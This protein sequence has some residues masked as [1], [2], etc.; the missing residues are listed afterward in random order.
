MT[1]TAGA[2]CVKRVEY[3]LSPKVIWAIVREVDPSSYG[4][5][6]ELWFFQLTSLA[7][8]KGLGTHVTSYHGRSPPRPGMATLRT[9]DNLAALGKK[10]P[11]VTC[12]D[13]PQ[14]VVGGIS[15]SQ[16]VLEAGGHITGRVRGEGNTVRASPS[17]SSLQ[18]C[19]DGGFSAKL[20][21][22][23]PVVP[24]TTNALNTQRQSHVFCR[25]LKRWSQESCPTG[26]TST[27]SPS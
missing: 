25:G 8:V 18:C 27:P 16:I 10:A 9:K 1:S 13:V 17:E 23:R 14:N 26:S 6:S 22:Q 4:D 5:S 19:G 2:L 24:D 3:P 11:W 21:R 12:P 7:T 15:W 20:Q